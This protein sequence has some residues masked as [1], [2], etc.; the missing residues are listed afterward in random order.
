MFF[1][2]RNKGLKG[3]GLSNLQNWDEV[4]TFARGD[5]GML[6]LGDAYASSGYLY[7]MISMRAYALSGM[8][9]DILSNGKELD[10][11][12]VHYLSL[13]NRLSHWLYMVEFCL[14][15]YGQAYI[16]VDRN[17]FGR[18]PTPRVLLPTTVTAR[19]TT[20]NEI[21]HFE[22][23]VNSQVIRYEKDEI[24]WVWMP[25]TS[26]ENTPGQSPLM[27]CL[28]AASTVNN[29]LR[30]YQQYFRNG[31]LMPTI[32][33]F[34]D[35]TSTMPKFMTDEQLEGVQGYLKQM[36]GGIRR[37]FSFLALRGNVTTHT[38]GTKPNE[39]A[40][41]DI[42]Q[43]MREDMARAFGIPDSLLTSQQA[44]FAAS[45]ADQYNFYDQ[46]VVP[47][48]KT[49]ITEAINKL[50][51]LMGLPGYEIRWQPSR[52]EVY[53]QA[54]LQTAQSLL[55]LVNTIITVDEARQW[56]GLSPLEPAQKAEMQG[57]PSDVAQEVT[58]MRSWKSAY[59][60]MWEG[61]P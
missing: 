60:L 28:P 45:S 59:D 6:S 15:I 4:S 44:T 24:V 22:R 35:G 52:L 56:I 10:Q 42:M 37:A 19:Y 46:T 18:N 54:Q 2:M 43:M 3:I 50:F 31:A 38:I 5:D 55:A 9:R 11:E 49:F 30:F 39:L 8:P 36:L 17:E 57:M 16:V 20:Y 48:A 12:S 7:R 13:N 21:S 58:A 53:Q 51:I 29:L 47:H 1:E 27:A 23:T 32:F 14:M 34:G 25:H 26:S 41:N 33:T 61:Y 40:S